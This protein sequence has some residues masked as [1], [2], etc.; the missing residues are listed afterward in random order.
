MRPTLS[1]FVFVALLACSCVTA[2]AQS[3]DRARRRSPVV[4]VFEKS[5][6]AVVNIATTKVIR[7]ESL[8]F[9]SMYDSFFDMGRPLTRERQ[10]Q[11]VGSGFVVHPSGY[12]VTNYHVVAQTSDRS[13]IFADKQQKKTQIVAFDAEHDLAVLK[14]DTDGPLPYV[15]LARSDDIMI[16]ETVVAI[17][18][19]L[20][21]Q[22][23]VTTGI[24]SALDR[25]I[26]FNNELVYSGLIQTDAAINP[27]NSGG[28]LL[29]INGDLIGV[30]TAIRGDA[31][32]VG[33][34]IPVD[35]IWELL[36]SMLDIE[37][38]QRVSFG[39]RVSGQ[40][41][42]V[43]EVRADTPA[44]RSGLSAGDRVV[45]FNGEPIR[46]GIDYYVH[47]L[48]LKPGDAIALTVDRGGKMIEAKLAIDVIP[49]PDGEKIA[50]EK[51]GIA[52]TPV[53]ASVKRRLDLDDDFGLMVKDVAEDSPARRYIAPGDLIVQMNQTPVNSLTDAGLAL[54]KLERGQ[55]V[56]IVGYRLRRESPVRWH[57]TLPTMK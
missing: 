42:E 25:E 49:P 53:P 6:D 41:A 44:A 12:V 39:L 7:Y 14:V 45:K 31:Q 22:H 52:L 5:R 57:V 16:G 48:E 40:R 37:R 13:V 51:L 29:N 8:R 15:P 55:R 21:L 11:S 23:T 24:V 56:S 19:P 33:F 34:A 3:D 46:D 17:G 1:R 27:G 28:P 32:N 35:R 54:E 18:N 26:Q 2:F 38:R 36:P 10:V 43:S 30:N 4:E 47:L 50:F 20:G 9:E